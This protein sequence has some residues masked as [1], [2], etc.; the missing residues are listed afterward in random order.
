ML[1]AFE[2][3]PHPF[4]YMRVSFRLKGR[5]LT[6]HIKSELAH[7]REGLFNRLGRETP[8][9]AVCCGCGT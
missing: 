2:Q 6:F 8:V 3:W 5:K 4:C 7:V 9:A 1:G